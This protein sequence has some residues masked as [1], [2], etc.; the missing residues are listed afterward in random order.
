VRRPGGT[1]GIPAA[2][3]AATLVA[4]ILGLLDDGVI[5]V[6]AWI[7]LVLPL[8]ALVPTATKL[9]GRRQPKP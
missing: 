3:A 9:H 6:I 8:A 7:G 4:L 2:L 1:F 5:D